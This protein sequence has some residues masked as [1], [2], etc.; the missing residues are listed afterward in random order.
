MN[1]NT[2]TNDMLKTWGDAQ[3][4][5]WSGWMNLAQGA[6]ALQTGQM[7]DLMQAL[8]MGADTSSG[9]GDASTQRVTGNIFGTPE[10]MTRSMNLLARAWQAAAPS[11]EQGKAWQPDVQKLVQQWRD[12][13]VNAP[14]R[15]ASM[16]TDFSQIANSLFQNWS[17]LLGMMPMVSQ[18]VADGQSGAGFESGIGGLGRMLGFGDMFQS[19]F[20]KIELGQ[21]PLVHITR[22]K[23]GKLLHLTDT[24][25][26]LLAAQQ[27]YKKQL[28]EALSNSVVKTVEHLAK[29]AEKGEKVTSPRDLQRIWFSIADKDLIQKFNTPEFIE[30]QGKL[31]IALTNH[32]IAQREVL[33]MIYNVLEIPTRSEINDAYRS[34]AE[35]ER[36][37]RQLERSQKAP[38]GTA[39]RSTPKNLSHET[40]GKKS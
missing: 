29:L 36:K 24:M 3:K 37:V 25:K 40:T 15:A 20:N 7:P 30:M 35:L 34:I 19:P 2:Q 22:E 28:S 39:K 14:Q 13:F 4:Q 23:M 33:E 18:A 32:K 31:V 11:I 8:R 6:N 9:Q 27:G 21:I 16:Q 5:L 38:T 17:P 26:D 1:W 10:I 12:E